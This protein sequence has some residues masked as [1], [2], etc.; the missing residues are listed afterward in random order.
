M[1]QQNSHGLAKAWFF[2]DYLNAPDL[3]ARG[4]LA[5]MDCSV[6]ISLKIARIEMG[7]V[8]HNV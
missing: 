7:I 4:I 2:S 3:V 8:I 1:L 6:T 5:R